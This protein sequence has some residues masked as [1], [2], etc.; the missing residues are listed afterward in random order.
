MI[1]PHFSHRSGRDADLLF[2]VRSE[3]GVPLESSGFVP[4][5]SDGVGYDRVRKR[6]VVLDVDRQWLLVKALVEDADAR[7]QWLFCHRAIRTRLL[8]WGRARGEATGTLYRAA[9]VLA[10]PVPGGA[11]DDHLHVRVACDDEE[12]ARGCEPFG[13]ERP[14]LRSRD[15]TPSATAVAAEDGPVRN[16]VA[17][18]LAPLADGVDPAETHGSH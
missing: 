16:L 15:G 6:T 5:G 10:Q 2:F 11:H 7:V 4:L 17:E 18:L 9:E 8:E 12:R 14:W 13:P 3:D 1:L